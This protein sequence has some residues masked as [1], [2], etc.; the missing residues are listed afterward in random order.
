[1]RT[2]RRHDFQCL[3]MHAG[4][5]IDNLR[6]NQ[7]IVYSLAIAKNNYQRRQSPLCLTLVIRS[8]WP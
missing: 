4:N 3:N 8:I 5:S 7:V 6:V 2:Y 1:M